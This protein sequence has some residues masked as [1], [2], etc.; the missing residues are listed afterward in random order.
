MQDV[1]N[2]LSEETCEALKFREI[3]HAISKLILQLSPRDKVIA[4]AI[5][6]WGEEIPPELALD[7]LDDRLAGRQLKVFCKG[8]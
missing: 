8:D 6:S 1:L 7:M 4:G 5:N 3:K 2:K